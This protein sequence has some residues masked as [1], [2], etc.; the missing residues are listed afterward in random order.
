MREKWD[1]TPLIPFRDGSAHLENKKV[2]LY[3]NR[4]CLP[5][6]S[7]IVD[8]LLKTFKKSFSNANH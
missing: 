5:I 8:N 2:F 7:R 1:F 3:D 4:D 6:S